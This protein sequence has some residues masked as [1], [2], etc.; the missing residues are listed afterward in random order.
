MKGTLQ[1]KHT[2]C[3][4]IFVQKQTSFYIQ[5]MFKQTNKNANENAV[6]KPMIA[7]VEET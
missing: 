4:K 6:K 3:I 2:Y 7:I 5:A 1:D